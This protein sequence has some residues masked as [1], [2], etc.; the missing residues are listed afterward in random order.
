MIGLL[1]TIC[2]AGGCFVLRF[3]CSYDGF[4]VDLLG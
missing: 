1:V 2:V 3:T 4:A